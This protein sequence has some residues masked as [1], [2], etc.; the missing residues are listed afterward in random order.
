MWWLE[1]ETGLR[2]EGRSYDCLSRGKGLV[3]EGGGMCLRHGTARVVDV[4]LHAAELFWVRCL[5]EAV[6]QVLIPGSRDFLYRAYVTLEDFRGHVT[7]EDGRGT[8]CSSRERSE[9]L[10]VHVLTT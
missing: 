7:S 6:S 8:A 4:I 5:G 3:G 9:Y 10:C 2:H 1:R